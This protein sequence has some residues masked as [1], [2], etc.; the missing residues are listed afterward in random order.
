MKNLLVISYYFPP[1]GGPGVQ[2]VLKL[3]KY[4]PEFGIRP[5][6][7]TVENGDYPARDE[8]LLDEIPKDVKVYRTH[9]PEPYAVYR[10]F[11]GKAPGS[12]VDV[13]TIPKPGEKRTLTETVS[14]FVRSN[15]FI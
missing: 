12:A 15:F 8:S 13:N 14:E 2:R 6:V 3:I 10:R 11:T 4:L 7:L 9:I 1:S 5:V